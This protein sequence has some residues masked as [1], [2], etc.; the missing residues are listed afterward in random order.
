[1]TNITNEF[2]QRIDSILCLFNA[3]ETLESNTS[4]PT[5]NRIA[6]LKNIYINSIQWVNE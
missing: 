5:S 2:K 6:T 3:N 1:M 4:I